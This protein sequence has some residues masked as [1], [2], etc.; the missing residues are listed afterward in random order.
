MI[1]KLPESI[2]S[3]IAAGEIIDRPSQIAK[4]LV[5]NS[6][7]AKAN[8]IHVNFTN[9]GRDIVV[10]DDGVGISKS[11]LSLVLDRYSTSKI[12][13]IDDLW[14]LDS[15]GF[16]GEAL[17]S[18]SAVSNLSITSKTSTNGAF[19]LIS[20]FGKVES[21]AKS[22]GDNGTL[23]SVKNLFENLP[24][25]LK[26]LKS[27]RSE[28][29]NL[30]KTLKALAIINFK[31]E[32]KLNQDS[33]LINILNPRKS[34]YERVKDILK[35]D[36]LYHV[37]ESVNGFDIEIC[38]SSPNNTQKTSQNI[39]IFA[40]NRWIQD[41]S[42][43][44]AILESYRTLLMHREFPIVVLNIHCKK[45]EIDV[46]VHPTKSRVKF[47]RQS[48]IFSAI[49][50]TLRGALLK[51]PWLDKLAPNV[52]KANQ[53]SST[54]KFSGDYFDKV[55]FSKK[56]YSDRIFEPSLSNTRV[57]SPSRVHE[58]ISKKEPRWQTLDIIGQCNCTY[59]V[60]QSRDSLILIDQHAAHERVLFEKLN[61]AFTCGDIKV[62]NNL[63]PL[64]LSMDPDQLLFLNEHS[65]FLK[66]MGLDISLSKNFVEVLS[67]P[68]F[69]NEKGLKA[70]L[71]CMVSDIGS[72][73]DISSID[74]KVSS[75]FATMA[76][77]SAIRAGKILSNL[78]IKALLSQMDEYSL[79]SF[80]PHGRPVFLQYPFN[81]LEVEFCRTV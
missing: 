7:D 2:V 80:Y 37:K 36:E 12:S 33:E 71:E 10:K 41:K 79:S 14:N 60:T 47:L 45:D 75:V 73:G 48:D 66:K 65:S 64:K 27:N 21:M 42:L 56:N 29:F 52:N 6:I 34:L 67:H 30:K 54:R 63:I 46:N 61:Q 78:E 4:E 49:V 15:F 9:G 76:C 26:F 43:Q 16:R 24:A 22:H 32:F 31:T 70:G 35:L 57:D 11:D 68:V 19:N 40:Q 1:I 62:Q 69:L 20:R 53:V 44:M 51:S 38:F 59:I 5:E 72:G 55:N 39:W 58:L 23:I 13:S 8:K 25:R 28:S 18:I 3:K 77:H 17:H 50:K 74:K 81:K